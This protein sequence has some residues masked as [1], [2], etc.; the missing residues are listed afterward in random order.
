RMPNPKSKRVKTALEHGGFLEFPAYS[1]DCPE[2][3]LNW[4]QV[5]NR[6]GHDPNPYVD[7]NDKR[8]AGNPL[9]HDPGADP[10]ESAHGSTFRDTSKTDDKNSGL[11]WQGGVCAVCIGV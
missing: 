3:H 11:H 9:Y 4:V 1:D 7:H 8:E 6:A 2:G 10:E 5:V